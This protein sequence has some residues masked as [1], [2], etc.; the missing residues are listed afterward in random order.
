MGEQG[1]LNLVDSI[2]YSVT[3]HVLPLF[4]KKHICIFLNDKK[5][6]AVYLAQYLKL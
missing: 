4:V 6:C 3:F 5:K 2:S 1:K